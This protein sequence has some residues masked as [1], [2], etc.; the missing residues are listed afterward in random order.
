MN[1]GMLRIT[2]FDDVNATRAR[3]VPTTWPAFVDRL[4]KQSPQ[5]VKEGR[6][7]KLATFG[8]VRSEKNSLRHDGNLTA[9]WGIEGDYNAGLISP[10]EAR[11]RLERHHLRAVVATTWSHTPEH[12]RWRV[13]APLTRPAPPDARQRYVAGLNGALG[14]VL[15]P[16]SFTLSQSYFIGR[17]EDGEYLVLPTFEDPE[18]GITLDEWDELDAVAIGASRNG[19]RPKGDATE[20]PAV[21]LPADEVQRIRSALAF[22]GPAEDRNAWLRIG[23]ALHSTEA[24]EQAYGLWSEWSLQS[25][26][27]DPADQRRVWNS[28]G[29]RDGVT[30][31]SLFHEAE[32]NGWTRPTRNPEGGQMAND[33]GPAAGDEPH[34][35]A[36]VTPAGSFVTRYIE[37][38]SQRTDAPPEAHELAAIGI[39]SALAGPGPRIPLATS[40]DGLGLG[41]WMSYI[42]NSTMG[43]KTTVLGYPVRMLKDVL[44]ENAIIEWEGSP[45]GLIQRLQDRDHKAAVFVRDEYSGLLAQMNRGGHMAGLSQTFIRAFNGLPLEN[46]RTRKR[47]KSTGEDQRDTD[48]VEEPY[49]VKLTATTWDAFVERATIDNVL[50]GFLARFVFVTATATPRRQGRDRAELRAAWADLVEHARE[51]HEAA[52]LF[53]EIDVDDNVLDLCWALEQEWAERARKSTRPNAAGPALKRLADTVL[54][55]AGLFALEDVGKAAPRITTEDWQTARTIGH[56]WM[57]ST[58]RVIEALGSTTFQRDCDAVDQTIRQHPDGAKLSDIYRAHRRLKKR[59]FDEILAAL[60]AQG[61]IERI[62]S[63]N[64]SGGR[65]PVILRPLGRPA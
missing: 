25:P 64:R 46:I 18:D 36:I 58:L 20:P 53:R 4:Q 23:M 30:L 28:F 54:R 48:R 35:F 37:H 51:Y 59:D 63:E 55:V 22:C 34:P 21:V 2:V 5:A 6:L 42:V 50:D 1:D 26:K 31:G 57:G 27:F 11:D 65:P 12:P 32:Q 62:Q 13:F 10:T 24:G 29:A 9:I 19:G 47:N 43:R 3:E 41:L 61:R 8:T 49:L 40:L 33:D 7:V 44:G 15:A 14:G 17:R 60:E 38:V 39:L 16:E 56:R 45:Q 52:Q